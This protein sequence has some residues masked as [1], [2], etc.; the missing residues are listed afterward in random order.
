MALGRQGGGGPQYAVAWVG[1]VFALWW[2]ENY[3]AAAGAG[4]RRRSELSCHSCSMLV[5]VAG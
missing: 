1:Q 5:G 3:S 2:G 4:M